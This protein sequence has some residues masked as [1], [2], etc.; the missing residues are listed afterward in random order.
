MDRVALAQVVVAP[1]IGAL[2]IAC[3]AV[4]L[5]VAARVIV[6][7][8][9]SAGRPLGLWY[10]L[11]HWLP[12]MFVALAATIEDRT[13]IAV[14]VA[15]ATSVAALSLNLGVVAAG[16][17]GPQRV[18]ASARAWPFVLPASLLAL[19]AGFSGHLTI[20]HA[21]VMLAQGIVFLIAWPRTVPASADGPLPLLDPGAITELSGPP[22]ASP[23]LPRVLPL[24]RPAPRPTRLAE[25]FLGLLLASLGAW[26]AVHGAVRL[27]D[28][29]KIM[30]VGLVAAAVIGP[31]LM[32]PAVN[33]GTNLGQRGLWGVATDSYVILTLLNLCLLL[34]MIVVASYL[35]RVYLLTMSDRPVEISFERSL[36]PIYYP[37]A[38]WR[39]DTVVLILLA[40]LLVPVGM[41][42]WT[43]GRREGAG[44]I[45]G[46][47]AYLVLTAMLGTR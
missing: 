19:T 11:A 46:Y 40:L 43:L 36:E 24:F 14:G 13:D 2:L 41:G 7:G 20:V 38:V 32:L 34:P 17:A 30:T 9:T 23:V 21:A 42:R 4:A 39:V 47:A 8:M 18:P 28:E 16:G 27:A 44:L 31:L 33:S 15:F 25:I 26:G 5:Y 37:M 10:A 3:S 45:I 29:T 22:P 12:I 35:R 6:H 1:G